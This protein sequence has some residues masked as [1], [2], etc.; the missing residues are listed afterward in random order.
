MAQTAV[1]VRYVIKR[2]VLVRNISE[3]EAYG[4]R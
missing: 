3:V 4:R 2:F 1:L